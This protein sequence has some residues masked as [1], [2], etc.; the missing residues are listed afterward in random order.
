MKFRMLG[1]AAAVCQIISGVSLA[2][3]MPEAG[4]LKCRRCH[5]IDK[6]GIAPSFLDVSMKY[7]GDDD[8]VNKIIANITDGG[9]FGWNR[10]KMPERGLGAD[11]VEIRAMAEYI[12]R[13]AKEK[14]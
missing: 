5:T 11:D 1:L 14:D 2:E 10:G 8:A 4:L 6:K 9:S 13:L 12:V 3:D 7:K